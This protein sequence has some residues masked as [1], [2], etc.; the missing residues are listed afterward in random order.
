M[1][2]IGHIAGVEDYQVALPTYRAALSAG[3]RRTSPCGRPRV[4]LRTALAYVWPGLTKA[5]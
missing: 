1:L 2:D 4:W 3:Q 5:S